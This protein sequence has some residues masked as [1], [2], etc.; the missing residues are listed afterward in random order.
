MSQPLHSVKLNLKKNNCLNKILN[1]PDDNDI[2][3]FLE[4]DMTY[5]DNMEEKTKNFRFAPV[6]KKLI[7]IILVN[8]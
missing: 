7:L 1:T 4:V 5:P 6:N 3:Y 2:G 8:I